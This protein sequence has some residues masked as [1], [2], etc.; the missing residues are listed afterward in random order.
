[1]RWTIW[2]CPRDAAIARVP[3]RS[4]AAWDSFRP[5]DCIGARPLRRFRASLPSPHKICGHARL[6]ARPE[7]DGR[8]GAELQRSGQAMQPRRAVCSCR[9][10]RGCLPTGRPQALGDLAG[11]TLNSCATCLRHGMQGH[12][13]GQDLARWASPSGSQQRAPRARQD[14]RWRAPAGRHA[15]PATGSR[16]V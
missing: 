3:M 10:C 8:P 14:S 12:A 2:R 15:L 16:H 9:D 6:A 1:M 5:V 7:M 11:E 13:V 4:G